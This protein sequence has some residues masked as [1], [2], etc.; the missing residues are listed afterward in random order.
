MTSPFI[1]QQHKPSTFEIKYLERFGSHEDNRIGLPGLSPQLVDK[2][3]QMEQTQQDLEDARSKFDAWK[4][5]FQRKRKDIE[6]K[7]LA[8][9]EQ[10][11]KLDQF[12]Q[13]H[14]AELEKAKKRQREEIKQAKSIRK[15]LDDINQEELELNAKS[16]ALNAELNELKPYAEYLQSVVESHE[17][18]TFDNVDAIL[19]RYQSL[20]QTRAEYLDLYESLVRNFGKEEHSLSK[21]LEL[22]KSYLIHSSMDLNLAI[23]KSNQAKKKNEYTR[24]SIIKDVQRIE[25]K[26]TE[27][28]SIESS[29]RNIYTRA[30]IQSGENKK[31]ASQCTEKEML[32]FIEERIL[33]LNDI[34]LNYKANQSQYGG[35][36]SSFCSTTQKKDSKSK[37]V[38]L[39]TT[40]VSST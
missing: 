3:R 31:K 30:V 9:S 21:E 17:C 26:S 35:N 1:T 11:R 4:V 6:E 5:N 14:N 12:I 40:N 16:E 38:L 37:S 8:L 13:H 10:K 22:R 29:I 28:A 23:H 20:S 32:Q 18:Q 27:L 36:G 2:Q 24:N 33:D 25:D 34:Y 7:Q 19:L 15:E 39:S